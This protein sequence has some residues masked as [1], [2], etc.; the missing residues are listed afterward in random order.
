MF[1]KGITNYE[2]LLEFEKTPLDRRLTAFNT[3]DL[4][5]H[6]ASLNPKAPA[7]SYIHSGEHFEE[8]VEINYASLMA[9]INRTA[10]LFH[11]LGIGSGDVV[12]YLLPAIPQT[13]YIF[14]GVEAVG[15][16]NPINPMLEAATL[17]DILEAAGTKVLVALGDT[18]GSDIWQKVEAIRGDLPKLKTIVRIMGSGEKTEGVVDYEEVIQNYN[19]ESLDF[20]RTILPDDIASILHTGGTTG[21]PKLAPRSHLN[22]VTMALMVGIHKV[23]HAGDTVL[24]G[25]PLFHNYGLMGTGLFPFSIGA[26]VVMLT[27]VGYRDPSVLMNLWKIVA[28]YRAV[29]FN[30]VP[31]VISMLLDVPKGDADLSSLRFTICG[32]APL[33]I[34]MA[35]RF[36]SYTGVKVVEGYGLT[37]GTSSS[38]MSPIEGLIKIGSVGLRWPYQ[39]M[40]VFITD[41]AGNFLREAETDEIGSICIKGPN[42]FK[43][44]LE[45]RHN[46]G[47]W[48]K[49]GWLNTGDMG[50]Q[51]VD[52]YFWLTGRKKEL[53]IRGGHNID[54]ALIE[55][56]L[57][58][59]PGVLMAAAVGGPDPRVGELP[60][61]YVQLQPGSTLTIEE[62]LAHLQQSVGER[63]AVPAQV[64]I[65]DEMPLTTVGKIFKPALKW[66]AIEQVYRKELEVLGDMIERMDIQV[67]EDKIHGALALI[68]IK[69]ALSAKKVEIRLRIEELLAAYTTQYRLILE[70]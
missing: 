22:E 29:F 24:G 17:R 39:E 59:L 20:D 37:E 60:V 48:A 50:R 6:G 28:R 45:E 58:R 42:V 34:E 40:K 16:V 5:K 70:D 26:H 62:I 44:Y 41:D 51:D 8:P 69:P 49:P 54:P 36:E 64:F 4:I 38:S 46:E 33:S 25:L 35:T 13:H 23:F 66:Q 52:Q 15:I 68:T 19:G 67:G 47:V 32:A 12:S 1:E 63:A 7:I 27:P 53:I 43:G 65:V 21:T 57:Y 14:W 31:T 9:N 56:P 55:E 3:Y 10:N 18:P 11:N 2:E 30:V 61:A